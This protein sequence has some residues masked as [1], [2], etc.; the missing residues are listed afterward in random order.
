[1]IVVN[2]NIGLIIVNNDLIIVKIDLISIN[3][4][5]IDLVKI[6]DHMKDGNMDRPTD[7]HSSFAILEVERHKDPLKQLGWKLV[8]VFHNLHIYHLEISHMCTVPES[9]LI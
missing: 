2:I 3:I 5:K 7:K 1:M 6:T 8:Y 9:H 4:I